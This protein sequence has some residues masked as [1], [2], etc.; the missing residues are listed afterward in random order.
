VEEAERLA[1][2]AQNVSTLVWFNYRRVPAITLAKEISGQGN[3]G[4]N[5][6]S[7]HFKSGQQLSL[8]NR[9]TEVAVQD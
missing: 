9:P 4:S 2:P 6:L 5:L 1:D 8:Q 7:D 3:I